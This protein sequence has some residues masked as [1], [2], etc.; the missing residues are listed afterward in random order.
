MC[1]PDTGKLVLTSNVFKKQ[2]N[3]LPTVHSL[4]PSVETARLA[5]RRHI[6]LVSTAAGRADACTYAGSLVTIYHRFH[7]VAQLLRGKLVA[8]E[9][10]G[11]FPMAIDDD[12]V[13]GMSH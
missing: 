8:L 3:I 1:I 12:G 2:V 5:K 10:R 6:R 4:R 11:Q 13:Q 7:Q 9:V